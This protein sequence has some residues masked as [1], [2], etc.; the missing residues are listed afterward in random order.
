MVV[1]TVVYLLLTC[2]LLEAKRTGFRLGGLLPWCQ[3]RKASTEAPSGALAPNAAPTID[4]DAS[5]AVKQSFKRSGAVLERV[6]ADAIS[7]D[8]EIYVGDA[9]IA[10][11]GLF[12]TYTRAANDAKQATPDPVPT[13]SPSSMKLHAITRTAGSASGKVNAMSSSSVPACSLEC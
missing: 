3:R 2:A 10:R 1:L 5:Y 12:C 7:V 11:C 6:V 4:L 13:D 8:P 9:A